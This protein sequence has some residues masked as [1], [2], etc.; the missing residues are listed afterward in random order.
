LN[1]VNAWK[2]KDQQVGAEFNLVVGA[3]KSFYAQLSKIFKKKVK[4][5]KKKANRDDDDGDDSGAEDDDKYDSDKDNALDGDDDSGDDA[6]D[7]DSCPTNCDPATYEKVLDLRTKRQEQDEIKEELMKV[8]A[9]LQ[10][11]YERHQG[12]ERNIDRQL[13]ETEAEIEAFQTQKQAYVI[14]NYHNVAVTSLI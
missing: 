10:K 8:V 6:D 11:A 3:D 5:K 4:G 13:T 7:D 1:E 12:R 2:E 14:T 9:E